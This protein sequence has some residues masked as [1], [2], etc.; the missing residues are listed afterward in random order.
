MPPKKDNKK[1]ALSKPDNSG[2]P[3]LDA[4]FKFTFNIQSDSP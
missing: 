1:Q 4:E 2:I 3:K